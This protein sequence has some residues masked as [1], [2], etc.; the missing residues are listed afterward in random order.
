MGINNTVLSDQGTV[1]ECTT[2][3][4]KATYPIGTPTLSGNTFITPHDPTKPF[5]GGRCSSASAS[6]AQWQHEGYDLDSTQVDRPFS[7][8]DILQMIR[9][10]LPLLPAGGAHTFDTL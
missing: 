8:D 7:A 1:Y 6:F 4:T 5:S 2:S 9:Q 10:K 3:F